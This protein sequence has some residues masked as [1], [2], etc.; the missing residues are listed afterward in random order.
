MIAAILYLIIGL[1]SGFFAYWL[2]YRNVKRKMIRENHEWHYTR[3]SLTHENVKKGVMEHIVLVVLAVIF[4]PFCLF[5]FYPLM[6]IVVGSSALFNW[7]IDRVEGRK[8]DATK[9]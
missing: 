9:D 2:A 7:A 8:F 1:F 6:G 3:M 5:V 4:W